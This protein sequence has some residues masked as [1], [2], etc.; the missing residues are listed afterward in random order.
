MNR[1]ALETVANGNIGPENNNNVEEN[2]DAFELDLENDGGFLDA[3]VGGIMMISEIERA[4]SIERATRLYTCIKSSIN[5]IIPQCGPDIDL[6][7]INAEKYKMRDE[8]R[9]NAN[10]RKRDARKL[11]ARKKKN[12]GPHAGE[13]VDT[14][15][16]NTP[17][18]GALT[19]DD[20][21][22]VVADINAKQNRALLRRAG[23][24]ADIRRQN[25]LR[26]RNLAGCNAHQPV[27]T[28]PS[29][30]SA[31][32][33]NCANTT[34]TPDCSEHSWVPYSAYSPSGTSSLPPVEETP[35]FLPSLGDAPL[36]SPR[37]SPSPQVGDPPSYNSL[38]GP[39]PSW[40]DSSPSEVL[41][42]ERNELARLALSPDGVPEEIDT[43]TGILE[44][45]LASVHDVIARFDSENS[46][47]ID[48]WVSHL[49]N[50]A[51]FSYQMMQA[52]TF[53]D[54]FMAVVSYAKKYNNN[55]SLTMD[56][57]RVINQLS[58]FSTTETLYH[59][60]SIPHG[61]EVP[62]PISYT[63]IAKDKWDMLKTNTI[64]TKI[65][66]LITTAMSLTICTLKE[67]KWTPFG[68][69]VIALHAAKKQAN[70]VDIIDA[71]VET[72]T[73]VAET[74][75][76]C[77]STGSIEPILYSDQNM[78]QYNSEY[79]YIIAY[80]DTAL[81]GNVDDM[82]DFENKLKR[83]LARTTY[84]KKV[85]TDGPTALWLQKRY[86]DLVAIY[87]RV[88]CKRR[89]TQMRF[90]PIGFSLY[91]GTGVGKS[92]LGK[93]TMNTSLRSMGYSTEKEKQ[94]THD[95]FDKYQ[96]TYT[97]DIEGVFLDDV[98]NLKATYAKGEQVPSAIII[99]FFNNISAQAIKAELAEKGIVFINFKCGVVTTN[100]RDLDAPIYSNC[101]ESI[102][103][104]L[105][106][107]TVRVKDKFAK[108]GPGSPLDTSHP[109]LRGA[110][111]TKDVWWIDVDECI[112]HTN[113]RTGESSYSFEPLTL[114][115]DAGHTICRDLGLEDYLRVVV[116]LS[117]R[118]KSHQ[119]GLLKANNDF[120]KIEYCPHCIPKDVC[121]VCKECLTVE[122][123]AFE[124]ISGLLATGMYN[125]VRNYVNSFLSPVSFF[126]SLLGF[127]PVEK[128]TERALTRELTQAMNETAT[129]LIVAL[130]P[131]CIFNSS[132]F[133][134]TLGIWQRT[135]A[136]RDLR[137]HAQVILG[138]TTL[139]CIYYTVRWK[140]WRVAGS[141]TLGWSLALPCYLLWTR[142]V[143]HYRQRYVA[144]RNILPEYVSYARSLI[145]PS[146]VL[147]GATL[148]LGIKLIHM[149]NSHRKIVTPHDNPGETI[150]K[151]EVD[152]QPGWFGY[153]S[154]SLGLK[155]DT[156]SD[157]AHATTDMVINSVKK[158]LCWAVFTRPDGSQTR[159]NIFFPQ[160]FRAW[161]P[162]HVF[163]SNA[164]MTTVPHSSL[165]IKV[166]RHATVGGEFT[167]KVDHCSSVIVPNMDMVEAFVP[168]MFDVR[169]V[170]KWLPNSRPS[171]SSSAIFY[172]RN[173][174]LTYSQEVVAAKFGTVG[175][176]YCSMYGASYDSKTVGVGTCM[177][178][179]IRDG[180]N[181]C[182]LGFHIGGNTEMGVCQTITAKE[183]DAS[184]KR[185][186]SLD[187][188][189]ISASAG[190]FP[191]T[192]YGRTVI[193]GPVHPHSHFCSYT[194]EHYVDVLG[195]AK[196]RSVCKS[197]VIPSIL[198]DAVKDV[199]GVENQWGPP[200]M[201]P[202][203]KHY[204]VATDSILDPKIHFIPEE[205]AW[206]RDDWMRPLVSLM[207]KHCKEE[208]VRPLTLKECIMGVPGRRFMDPIPMKTSAGFPI[209]GPKKKLFTEVCDGEVLV[210]R[211]PSPDV[212]QEM[213]RIRACWNRG[214]R[215]YPVF[216]ACLKDEPTKL[217]KSKVRVFTVIPLAFGLLIRKYFLPIIRFLGTHPIESEMAVG[218]NC[219]GP[220]WERM[221]NYVE[222]FSTNGDG[223]IGLDH[224]MFDTHTSSQ[225]TAD[226]YWCFY[227]LA[228]I[229][230]YPKDTLFEMRMCMSDFIHPC[231]D[232]NG[233][234]VIFYD[235][236][237]SGNNMTV[238]VNG[239]T[240]SKYI[241]IPF[242]RSIVL[243]KKRDAYFDDAGE[244]PTFRECVAATTYGD[245]FKGSVSESIR[246]LY[247]YLVIKQ[248]LGENNLE[249]TP[250]DKESDES[251][252]YALGELDFL[253]RNSVF[254]PEIGMTLGAL[255]Q[256][257]IFKS[258]H[259]NLKSKGATERE[260]AISCLETAAHEFFAHG[261]EIYDAR[262]SELRMVA[263]R[264]NLVV[265]ALKMTFDE[266]VVDWKTKY[267]KPPP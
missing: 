62:T 174:D 216:T 190:D 2:L 134:R 121:T 15:A 83:V 119:D 182:I 79:D 266:R 203:W 212:I 175:H 237:T 26:E 201:N 264:C 189:I 120:E 41:R 73:W 231:I 97:S 242:Y 235:S 142:R 130:T 113:P 100:Q 222:K 85:K 159:C 206:A 226:D 44:K 29:Y 254:I 103:R 221:M 143:E 183:S 46:A 188:I 93:L 107:V 155:V 176:K 200:M 164:D 267:L 21:P 202:N 36:N 133:Q 196:L 153:L 99:K 58:T 112:S 241:R 59:E 243:P 261:R 150:T 161:F 122:P 139:S 208:D 20:I 11:R 211:I 78:A 151:K 187:G 207:S 13:S 33:D 30:H 259:A 147:C 101:P 233:T 14:F 230:G 82:S 45:I 149:W 262:L 72:F 115:T 81:A 6:K 180:K 154:R 223:N 9:R 138:C 239:A 184:Q 246:H 70:A 256:D 263:E 117:Q 169:N 32:R 265:P 219:Q 96:S 80:A 37:T 132:L 1:L 60:E 252:F 181:P 140:P 77:L 67:I 126:N 205:L 49:E 55:R 98:A 125:A 136:T 193:S 12:I 118:H 114:R 213:D 10:R 90:Q 131:D 51:I 124:A 217:T 251:E 24:H 249:I 240:N 178:L 69:E 166:F 110:K 43:S 127:W 66:F 236:N 71:V 144:S 198:T 47:E 137:R 4:S 225:L 106:H 38:Y 135:A 204:N 228:V 27:D 195:S 84:L 148:V 192:Q 232:V 39:Q 163:F 152:E 199:C 168:N 214:E 194:K 19:S 255:D 158:N 146:T 64:F 250:P 257:S 258:L 234:I 111:L 116:A 220:Q 260:V 156:K 68:V 128:M 209:F 8:N 61:D 50:L 28:C 76:Q 40:F 104:R 123:H 42:N 5:L 7:T 91:G 145:K 16:S 57:F 248:E 244:I 215:A 89:N 172:V 210:D 247:N 22:R 141:L 108:S 179:I 197:E 54:C 238:Q 94:L 56:L 177:G 171:G 167:F 186:E 34:S 53:V 170:T 52:R 185:L 191:A 157:T 160:K 17:I 173:P 129:P 23:H 95:S 18:E 105:Y 253:K 63:R 245:D 48:A 74:G 88:V 224:R 31:P 65:S 102:L 162:H 92:T 227:K 75:W 3:H 86:S 229:A 35:H 109:E 87:E 165:T 25:L 218:I